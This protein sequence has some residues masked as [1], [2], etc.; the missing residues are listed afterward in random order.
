MDNIKKGNRH[1]TFK[2][3]GDFRDSSL[4][5]DKG[6]AFVKEDDELRDECIKIEKKYY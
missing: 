4:W 6:E 5:Y 3:V 2:D 1:I